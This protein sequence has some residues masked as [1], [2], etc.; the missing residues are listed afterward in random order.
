M[1]LVWVQLALLFA[2]PIQ[3]ASEHE[4]LGRTY[5]A[6]GEL[7]KAAA[8]YEEAIRLSPYDETYYFEAAHAYLLQQQFDPAVKILEHG[9]RVFDKSAQLELA[10]GVAYYGER[11]FPEATSAYLRTIDLAPEVQQPY[12]FLSK[13]LDQASD[14]FDDILPRFEHWATANPQDPQAQFV[15]AK[16]LLISGGDQ[17]KAEKLLR[18][19]IHLKDDQW[20]SHYELGTLLEKQRKFSEAA[21][22]LERS[23]AISPNQADVHY[24]LSRVYDRMHEPEKAAEQRAIHERLTT[25]GVK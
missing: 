22:E 19:S 10:L 4:R 18:A 3:A 5:E 16:G 12:V 6:K 15:Y 7:D 14:R 11:R 8:E 1:S 17:T 21:A 25:A 9:C 2:P 24:H 13:M 20:E 23:I